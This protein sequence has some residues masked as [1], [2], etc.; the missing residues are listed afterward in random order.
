M[1]SPEIHMSFELEATGQTNFTIREDAN[2]GAGTAVTIRN[3]NRNSTSTSKVTLQ[4]DGAITTTGTKIYSETF[5]VATNPA[6]SLGG[7]TR[8]ANEIVLKKNTKYRFTI[9]SDTAS[10]RISYK[11]FWYEN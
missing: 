7:E 1:S 9:S 4:R 2:W 3:S 6:Q 5:G 10:N 11:G 8:G